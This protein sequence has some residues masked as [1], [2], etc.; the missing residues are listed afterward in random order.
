MDLQVFLCSI[1]FMTR[2]CLEKE[3]RENVKRIFHGFQ[4]KAAFNP[5]CGHENKGLP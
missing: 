3:E 5:E 1:L 4:S 2:T